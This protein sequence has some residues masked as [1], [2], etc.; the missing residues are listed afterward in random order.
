MAMVDVDDTASYW[1]THILTA[2][3]GGLGLSFGGPLALSL[4][5]SNKL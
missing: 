5:S 1:Y 4:H 3:V 2:H